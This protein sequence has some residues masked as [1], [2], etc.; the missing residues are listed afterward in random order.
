MNECPISTTTIHTS[1]HPH[2]LQ[3]STHMHKYPHAH[4][5]RVDG[6]EKGCVDPSEAGR[7][8]VQKRYISGSV[9]DRERRG[10]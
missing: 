4:T 5:H 2:Q 10:K 8:T 1:T 3:R 6:V 7:R 9:K